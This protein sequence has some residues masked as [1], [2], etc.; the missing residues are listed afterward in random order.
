MAGIIE[1]EK[2]EIDHKGRLGERSESAGGIEKESERGRELGERGRT[3]RE[4]ELGESE[5]AEVN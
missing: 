1:W 2:G 5:S 4:R 3:R